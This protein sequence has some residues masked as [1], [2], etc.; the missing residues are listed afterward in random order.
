MAAKATVTYQPQLGST[1]LIPRFSALGAEAANRTVT[2]GTYKDN[3]DKNATAQ[4]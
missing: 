2:L 4:A 3:A 1:G